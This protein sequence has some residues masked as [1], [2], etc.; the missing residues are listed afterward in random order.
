MMS[1]MA[2]TSWASLRFDRS[3]P[4]YPRNPFQSEKFVVK[5][6]IAT[7]FIFSSRI[8]LHGNITHI[9]RGNDLAKRK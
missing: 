1:I 9:F 8:N 5:K 7:I 6:G 4:F 3:G 2:F